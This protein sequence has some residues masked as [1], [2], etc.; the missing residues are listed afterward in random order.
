MV[1]LYDI[2]QVFDLADRDGSAI[3]L[4]IMLDGGFIGR[5]PVD[6]D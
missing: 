4:V 2:I 5:A 1:L 6:G 3:L